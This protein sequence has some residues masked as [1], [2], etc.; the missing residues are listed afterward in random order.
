MCV[1][2]PMIMKIGNNRKYRLYCGI[3]R[4]GYNDVWKIDLFTSTL[5]NWTDLKCNTKKILKAYSIFT[6]LKKKEGYVFRV[7]GYMFL[8]M[9]I[10]MTCSRA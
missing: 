6:R 2:V 10:S 5:I 9:Y 4:E 8:C 1:H 7:Y 3:F